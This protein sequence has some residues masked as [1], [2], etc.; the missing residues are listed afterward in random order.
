MNTSYDLNSTPKT[1]NRSRYL[2]SLM[3]FSTP[4]STMSNR[5]INNLTTKNFNELHEKISFDD[6]STIINDTITD[7][8]NETIVDKLLHKFNEHKINFHN[9]Q[10]YLNLLDGHLREITMVL[11]Q[12]NN[13]LDY[14][15]SLKSTTEQL[16]TRFLQMSTKREQ[17]RTA[18][19][20]FDQSSTISQTLNDIIQQVLIFLLV[21]YV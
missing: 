12:L 4:M 9:T 16:E 1:I 10:N 20:N 11:N 14:N 18:I 19:N 2:E 17:I 5:W 7:N 8:N 21:L 3:D 13:S 6:N 15:S